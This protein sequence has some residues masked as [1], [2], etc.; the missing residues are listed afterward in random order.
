MGD[1][2]GGTG[3]FDRQPKWETHTGWVAG[4]NVQEKKMVFE[5]IFEV[6]SFV[7]ALVQEVEELVDDRVWGKLL[8]VLVHAQEEHFGAKDLDAEVEVEVIVQSVS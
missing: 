2:M 8:D 4:L 5:V 3:T 1:E 7:Q 6:L